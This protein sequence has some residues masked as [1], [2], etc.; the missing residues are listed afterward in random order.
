MWRSG[1]F[2]FSAFMGALALVDFEAGRIAN[3]IGDAGVACLLLSLMTQF[4]FMRAVVHASRSTG[5]QQDRQKLVAEAERFRSEHPWSERFSRA[6]W[7]LLLTSL[8]LR[9]VG[10]S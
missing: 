9:V 4:P 10:V 5:R 7:A 2:Y 3:G 1:F 6:G 8:L